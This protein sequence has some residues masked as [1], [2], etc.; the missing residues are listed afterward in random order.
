MVEAR[1]VARVASSRLL[2]SGDEFPSPR[3]CAMPL[4]PPREGGELAGC[5]A[6]AFALIPESALES[7]GAEQK[8]VDQVVMS[9]NTMRFVAPNLACDFVARSLTDPLW[10]MLV[11]RA[12]S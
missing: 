12:S 6:T 9:I 3:R 7:R 1:G 2:L 11:A 4:S 8:I 5:A 10:D